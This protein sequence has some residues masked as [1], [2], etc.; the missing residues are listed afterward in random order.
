MIAEEESEEVPTVPAAS[1][2]DTTGKYRKIRDL[3]ARPGVREFFEKEKLFP[4]V[5][6]ILPK[7]LYGPIYHCQD[8]FEYFRQ[9]KMT[10]PDDEDRELLGEL[11]III[12]VIGAFF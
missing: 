4:S 1:P 12:I 2:A 5:K 3:L 7:L 6:Y 8:Y 9:I 10:S 11:I